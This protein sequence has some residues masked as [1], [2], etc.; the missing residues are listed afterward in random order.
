MRHIQA[1]RAFERKETEL[2]ERPGLWAGGKKQRDRLQGH[3]LPLF[4]SSCT[5]EKSVMN[6]ARIQKT[7]R[8]LEDREIAP[9]P[10]PPP[11]KK[12][13]LVNATAL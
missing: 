8:P 6:T 2:G 12:I 7:Q 4:L 11:P 5:E 10:P 1:I 13:L 3:L 9:K